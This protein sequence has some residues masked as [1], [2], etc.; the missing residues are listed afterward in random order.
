MKLLNEKD[1]H[2]MFEDGEI[3]IAHAVELISQHLKKITDSGILNSSHLDFE[4]KD[5][6]MGK[7]EWNTSLED[8]L[9][10]TELESVVLDEV[11]IIANK[12]IDGAGKRQ[13]FVD[14]LH[15][16]INKTMGEE[17]CKD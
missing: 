1:V 3:S 2:Q 8:A 16:A 7:L 11:I 4:P 14:S 12:L 15:K 10:S 13:A 5:F 9:M 6:I 17:E